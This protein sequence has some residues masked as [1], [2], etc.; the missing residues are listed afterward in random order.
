MNIKISLIYTKRLR[1]SAAV[2]RLYSQARAAYPA[3]A[4]NAIRGTSLTALLVNTNL[5]ALANVLT[6]VSRA[7][8]VY[9]SF[10]S[11]MSH[12]IGIR[13]CVEGRKCFI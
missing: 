12:F 6:A 2:Q 11:F 10:H 7:L 8:S 5:S 4:L 1:V 13:Y 9:F 3:P